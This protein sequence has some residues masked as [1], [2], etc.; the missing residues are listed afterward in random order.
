MNSVHSDRFERLRQLD[1]DFTTPIWD[2]RLQELIQ[3]K[4][5]NGHCCPP[6]S[7]PKLGNMGS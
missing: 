1:F 3:Y 4:T 7:Y 2:T 6:L 5:I